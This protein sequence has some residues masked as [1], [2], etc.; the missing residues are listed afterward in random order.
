MSVLFKGGTVV[1]ATGR[2]PADVFTEDDKIKTI[3]TDLDNPADEVVDAKG[4]YI[5][6]GAIDPHTTVDTNEILS[7]HTH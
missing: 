6:P 4:K 2:Y 1:T 5:L 7:C 3:G